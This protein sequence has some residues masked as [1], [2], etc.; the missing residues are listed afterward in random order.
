[1]KKIVKK[2]LFKI[3]I[4][5]LLSL[6]HIFNVRMEIMDSSSHD[7]VKSDLQNRYFRKKLTEFYKENKRLHELIKK[8][9]VDQN[10]SL[11]RTTVKSKSNIESN[12]DYDDDRRENRTIDQS[13]S[14]IMFDVKTTD[15][16]SN[17]KKHATYSNQ[18]VLQ[19]NLLIN[20]SVGKCSA[21]AKTTKPTN[22]TK[23]SSSFHKNKCVQTD[24]SVSADRNSVGVNTFDK[25]MFNR[26]NKV[27]LFRPA[28]FDRQTFKRSY[29]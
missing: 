7:C 28:Y 27:G 8:L 6:S 1:M 16:S 14:P 15:S 18:S 19:R 20:S 23:S 29:F 4:F 3:V 5:V 2:L 17:S 26:Q 10:E 24:P 22:N 11:K 21:C 13:T 12:Y 9:L 25:D